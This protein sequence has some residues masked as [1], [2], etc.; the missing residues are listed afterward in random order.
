[1]I[2][3]MQDIGVGDIYGSQNFDGSILQE[4][5]IVILELLC[6]RFRT[7]ATLSVITT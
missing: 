5:Y 3:T 6:E 7:A 4:I 2:Q 1:M